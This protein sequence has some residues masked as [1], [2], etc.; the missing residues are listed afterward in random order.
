MKD[1]SVIITAGGIGKRMGGNYPKQFRL[2]A[3]LP[4]LMHTIKVFYDFAPEAQIIVTL[5]TE[6][7]TVWKELIIEYD[8]TIPHELVDGGLERF[9][10]VKNA[11]SKCKGEKIMI[12]DGVRPL[13][14]NETIQNG[15]NALK[16][17]LGAIPS[18]DIIDS[19]R[20]V[21]GDKNEA[22]NRSEYKKIQTP[23]CFR[24]QEIVKAYEVNFMQSFTDDASVF[25]AAGFSLFLFP[26]NEENLKITTE[27]DL[28]LTE[29]WWSRRKDKS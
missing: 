21:L 15:Y 18:I 20:R 7:K 24:K 29:F 16:S 2:L 19:L 13:V 26:G 8:I 10:S 27:K 12:H 6:W 25:E 4:I 9:H 22:V 28:L 17:H 23:Q 14:S 3:G 1:L 5:P 11:L